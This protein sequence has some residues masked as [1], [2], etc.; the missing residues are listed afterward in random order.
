MSSDTD[1][2]PAARGAEGEDAS[3]DMQS[4]LD[5][6]G[7]SIDDAKKK[8]DAGRPQGDPPDDDPLDDVAGGG[9]DHSEEA[10]DPAGPIVGPE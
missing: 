3:A 5:A 8:A 2:R 9:T 4:K 10:D 7:D 6:L 1:D